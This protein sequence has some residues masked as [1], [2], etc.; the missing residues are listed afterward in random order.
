M[1]KLITLNI[2]RKKHYER[3][4]ALLGRENPDVV[5]L[6]EVPEKFSI[7]LQ[8]LGYQT[9]FAPMSIRN[10]DSVKVTIG[11]MF[12]SKLQYSCRT[13]YYHKISPTVLEY[14]AT[15]RVATEAFAYLIATIHTPDN[16]FNIATTHLMDTRDGHKNSF[17]IKGVEC[18]LETLSNEE[19]HLICGDFNMP[20]GY[21]SL[22]EKMTNRYTDTIPPEYKSSLDRDLHRYGDKQLAQPIF[23]EYMVDY[24]FT[25]SPYKAENVRLEFGV[26]D[27]AAVIAN[28]YK[29]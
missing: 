2:E 18:L 24:I 10:I 16:T 29:E 19:P 26:S 13:E 14:D 8:K 22:Y 6:Q 7:H 15:N 1:L 5:C 20:R 3:V 21:N 27:H 12:A 25:R 17:Q 4:L 9:T 28:I 23:D 11:I